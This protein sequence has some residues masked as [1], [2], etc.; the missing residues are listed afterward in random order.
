MARVRRRMALSTVA[1]WLWLVF[2]TAQG[3]AQ[4]LDT[5]TQSAPAAKPRTILV[6]DTFPLDTGTIGAATTETGLD[7]TRP[8]LA[9]QSARLFPPL[10]NDRLFSIFDY[11]KIVEVGP[12]LSWFYYNEHIDINPLIRQ[13]RN[14]YMYQPV[15]V[16][17][18]KSSEYGAVLGFNLRTARLM[19]KPHLFF[20][21]RFALLLGIAN[22]YDGSLQGYTDTSAGVGGIVYK[23]SKEQKNNV[24][25]FGGVDAGYAFA[26]AKCPW[27]VYSGLDIKVWYRDLTFYSQQSSSASSSELYYWLSVPL[28]VVLTR[29]VSP[30]LL[31]GVEP[32]CDFMVYG[33]MQISETVSYYPTL[34]LG[35]RASFRLDAFM[36]TRLGSMVSLR[37]GP[38]A[39]FYGFGQ[40]NTDTVTVPVYGGYQAE[41]MAF[42]EPASA[43]FWVGFNF[44]VAFLRDRFKEKESR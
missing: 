33:R 15:I 12:S 4:P 28:G 21:S 10:D 35:N 26:N 43:S 22:S 29:P 8:V 7:T 31:F 42:C 41:Q 6:G 36:Q 23:P 25:V 2:Q 40:S 34:T 5:M 18:P 44:Q 9:A 1:A 17:T 19:R 32:R 11:A 3:P 16:G 14:E 38:Y 13:F 27:A 20:R 30:D 37:F 24:Y 39:M